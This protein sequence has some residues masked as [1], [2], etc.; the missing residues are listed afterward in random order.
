MSG[1]HRAPAIQRT[2]Q[3]LRRLLSGTLHCCRLRQIVG[4]LRKWGRGRPSRDEVDVLRVLVESRIKYPISR[5]ERTVQEFR[6][7][8]QEIVGSLRTPAHLLALAHSVV[9]RVIH[10]RFDVSR[11][12]SPPGPPRAADAARSQRHA[13][14]DRT[15]PLPR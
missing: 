10:D 5:W 12:D 15:A 3:A 11:R 1:G 4:V 9:Y 8:L 6:P 7:D 14:G 2:F 13:A